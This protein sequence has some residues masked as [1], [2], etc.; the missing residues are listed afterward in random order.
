MGLRRSVDTTAEY[1]PS[2]Q[3]H[4]III[5]ST[6]TLS[7]HP[8]HP[9]M[10]GIQALSGFGSGGVVL[11]VFPLSH[12]YAPRSAQYQ[13]YRYTRTSYLPQLY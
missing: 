13:P 1:H 8:I 7:F 12:L 4:P 5:N 6:L 2:L 9:D 3:S 10:Q 11:D